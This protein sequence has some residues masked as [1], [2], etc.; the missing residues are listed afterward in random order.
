MSNEQI[1]SEVFTLILYKNNFVTLFIP[2]I[3]I[4]RITMHIYKTTITLEDTDAAGILFFAN[5]FSIIHRA[6]E[7]YMSEIGYPLQAFLNSND[8][9]IILPIVH[10]SSDY[11]QPVVLGD[12]IIIELNIE[13]VSQSSFI[14]KYNLKNQNNVLIGN[15]KTVHVAVNKSSKMKSRLPEKLMKKLSE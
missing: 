4:K 11:V 13:K 8:L 6:Y 3:I 15:A 14:V 7:N 5:Q 12:T 9:D 10:A 2:N 1:R